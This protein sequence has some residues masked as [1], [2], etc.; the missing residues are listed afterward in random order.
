MIVQARVTVIAAI[1][2]GLIRS[3]GTS[4][5]VTPGYAAASMRRDGPNKFRIDSSRGTAT[6]KYPLVRV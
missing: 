4:R 3:S 1:S 6:G 5:G 2:F